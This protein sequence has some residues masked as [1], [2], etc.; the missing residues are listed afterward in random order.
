MSLDEALSSTTARQFRM[1]SI[2]FEREY[3]LPSRSDFYAMQNT[4]ELRSVIQAFAGLKTPIKLGDFV[5]RFERAKAKKKYTPEERKTVIERIK[6]RWR[7][8]VH[9]KGK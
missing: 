8:M 9:V 7:G 1:W 5:I 4:A 6:A 2:Y 3:D